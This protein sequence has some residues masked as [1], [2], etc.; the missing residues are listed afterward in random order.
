MPDAIEGLSSQA[1]VRRFIELSHLLD[2]VSGP[3]GE[4]DQLDEAAVVAKGAH[5]VAYA[6]AF[7]NAHGPMDMRTQLA[8]SETENEWF[9]FELADQKLRACKER[10]RTLR[11]QLDIARSLSAAMRAEWQAT[12]YHQ[13]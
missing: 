6:K 13:I 3:G 1:L 2:K 7:L 4:L 5:R 12:Q 8:I 10:L 11:D 9:A